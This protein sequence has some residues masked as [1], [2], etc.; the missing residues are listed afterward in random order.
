MK[1]ERI[2][3]N[4]MVTN[5]LLIKLKEGDKENIQ[6]VKDA[7]LNMKD[8]IDVLHNIQVETNIRHGAAAYD[9]L[10]M[11]RFSSLEDMETYLIHPLHVEIAKYIVEVMDSSASVCYES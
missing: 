4:K 9:I 11:T 5:N 10:L 2:E 1:T 8:K 7:L 6:K 3:V